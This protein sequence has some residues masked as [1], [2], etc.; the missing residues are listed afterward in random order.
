MQ[1]FQIESWLGLGQMQTSENISQIELSMGNRKTI[2]FSCPTDIVAVEIAGL[3]MQEIKLVGGAKAFFKNT[4]R[5][6]LQK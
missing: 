4:L 5:L 1:I 2:V 6:Y 3:A